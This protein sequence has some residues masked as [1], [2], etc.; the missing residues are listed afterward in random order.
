MSGAKKNGRCFMQFMVSS[1][2][3]V[4]LARSA[5]G[6]RG[7]CTHCTPFVLWLREP[8]L[9]LPVRGYLQRGQQGT[10]K[11]TCQVLTS[12]TE[13]QLKIFELKLIPYLVKG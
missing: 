10:C 5:A 6:A 12:G 1:G 4:P 3:A 11:G 7:T 9:F 2:V 8:G 13:C